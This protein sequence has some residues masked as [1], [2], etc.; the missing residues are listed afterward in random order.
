MT[1]RLIF[2]ALALV[3][4]ALW[5]G[6]NAG[7]SDRPGTPD[8][9]KAESLGRG[10]I[11]FSWRVAQ[12]EGG[13]YV[14]VEVTD[15]SGHDVGG[16]AGMDVG[17]GVTPFHEW[18]SW[19]MTVPA[20][21]KRCFRVRARTAAGKEGCVSKLWSGQSCVTALT[22]DPP[23]P[24]SGGTS[25]GTSTGNPTTPPPPPVPQCNV[26]ANVTVGQ[27]YNADGS[28]SE[29]LPPDSTHQTGCGATKDEA[30]EA[31]KTDLFKSGFSLFEGDEIPPGGCSFHV[32]SVVPGCNCTVSGKRKLGRCGGK[33][34]VGTWPYCCPADTAYS[35]GLCRKIV[36][37]G[38]GVTTQFK[39]D[40]TWQTN[41]ADGQS[42]LVNLKAD[43][44]GGVSG[45]FTASDPK[46]SGTFTGK[47]AGNIVMFSFKQANG[48]TGKGGWA[49]LG[50]KATQTGTKLVGNMTP[51]SAPNKKIDWN[52]TR[53]AAAA[54][55]ACTG[56]RIRGTGGACNCPPGQ[57]Y[58]RSERR[59]ERV[60]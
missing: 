11:T 54:A 10:S 7:C 44:G 22:E 56:G 49:I 30:V 51:D 38:K 12:R 26:T 8:Q 47:R 18:A 25:P 58:V 59:C 60:R 17:G 20:G 24:G 48:Q 50:D 41:T 6:A 16:P 35:R 21:T 9:T 32:D 55:D 29:Y 42:Y 34:P 14:D 13:R 37:T 2:A 43:A 19:T 27:C 45:S 36:H 3:L 46:K 28:P 4:S 40:G 31:A 1:D 5:G 52:G 15:G 23:R 53:A 39:A 33:K 57:H